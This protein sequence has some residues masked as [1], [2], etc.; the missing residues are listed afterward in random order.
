MYRLQPAVKVEVSVG[1][2]P[3]WHGSRSSGDGSLVHIGR[4]VPA[5]EWPDAVADLVAWTRRL[6]AEHGEQPG[7]VRR[8]PVHRPRALDRHL[9]VERGGTVP[10]HRRGGVRPGE[11]V[12]F[13]LAAGPADRN[14]D[15]ADGRVDRAHRRGR[16]AAA[17]VD[18]G[19]R[20]SPARDLDHRDQWQVDG[21]PA[22]HAH[23]APGRAARGHD[24]LRRDPRRRAPRGPRR[25]DR[26]GGRRGHPGPA[27]RGRR[28]AR[29][30]PRRPG[31]ARPGLRVQ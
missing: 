8:P 29:D 11:P 4:I 16:H 10:V 7:P 24:D 19:R 31:A 15:R 17:R 25:L 27:R 3:T 21:H 9:A 1:R 28:R 13:A 6:R 18:P 22:D 30:R 5:R 14:A 20:A 2:T 12:G 26:P 23:P